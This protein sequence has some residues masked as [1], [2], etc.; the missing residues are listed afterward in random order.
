MRVNLGSHPD[1]YAVPSELGFFDHEKRLKRGG[2]AW[3]RDQFADWGG[4]PIVG[5]ATPGYM[6]WRNSP[7]LIAARIHDLLPD[8]RLIAVLR[9]PVDRANSALIHHIKQERLRPSST[10]LEF[11]RSQPPEADRMGLVT[12]GWYAAALAPFKRSFGE[13][14][15]VMLYDDVKSDPTEV[16][17]RALRHIGATQQFHPPDLDE[18]IFSNQQGEPSGRWDLSIED[19]QELY[20]YFRDDVRQLEQLID[21]D[22]S[23]WEPRVTTS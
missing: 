14:L 15:L 2:V 16:Y 21:R 7:G 18:I 22:L 4:K 20:E 5:E 3:Y 23:M 1:V 13:Q 19:R 9:D 12:G 6:M 11:V 8:V 17:E 10:L